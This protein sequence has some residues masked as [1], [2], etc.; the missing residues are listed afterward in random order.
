MQITSQFKQLSGDKTDNPVRYHP[1]STHSSQASWVGFFQ[2]VTKQVENTGHLVETKGSISS[3]YWRWPLEVCF[4][5]L[6]KLDF[7]SKIGRVQMNK[8][9]WQYVFEEKQRGNWIMFQLKWLRSTAFLGCSVVFL[10]SVFP[11]FFPTQ[12]NKKSAS[13]IRF[14]AVGPSS[15]CWILGLG[16]VFLDI[17]DTYITDTNF[18]VHEVSKKKRYIYIYRCRIY[19][20]CIYMYIYIYIHDCTHFLRFVTCADIVFFSGFGAVLPWRCGY[21]VLKAQQR[22]YSSSDHRINPSLQG[23]H[24]LFDLHFNPRTSS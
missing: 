4:R 13:R 10:E 20:I 2:R 17:T 16:H 22:S 1:V 7:F 5:G 19:I 12:L 15:V 9:I 6:S 3:N 21:S 8:T 11:C 14:I 18:N 23:F 24:I